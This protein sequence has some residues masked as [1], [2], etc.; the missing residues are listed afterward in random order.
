MNKNDMNN[1]ILQ[2]EDFSVNVSITE[3]ENE[4]II[5]G[6]VITISDYWLIKEVVTNLVEKGYREIILTF[7]DAEIL[8]SSI[9]G[10]LLKLVLKENIKVKIKIKNPDL[11]KFL[12]I[13]GVIDVFEIEKVNLT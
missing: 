3:K 2:E 4:L 8:N 6:H 11:Y 7:N 12:K 1:L 13:L 5:T 10:F 9:I